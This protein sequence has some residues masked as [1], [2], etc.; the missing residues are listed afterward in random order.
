[1]QPKAFR[2]AAC[3]ILVYRG[4]MQMLRAAYMIITEAF[5]NLVLDYIKNDIEEP[6]IY[7]PR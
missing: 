4:S 2:L 7:C 3:I 6:Y 5:L 1:M